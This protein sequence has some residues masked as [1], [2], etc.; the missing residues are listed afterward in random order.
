MAQAGNRD[1]L[2]LW[3]IRQDAMAAYPWGPE[4]T[5]SASGGHWRQCFTL[6]NDKLA[7]KNGITF[8]SSRSWIPLMWLPS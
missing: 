8:F 4:E 7:E 1:A 3:G 6:P 2:G 5:R